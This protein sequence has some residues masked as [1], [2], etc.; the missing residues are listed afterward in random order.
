[1]NVKYIWILWQGRIR[2][3]IGPV[4]GGGGLSKGGGLGV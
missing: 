3:Q 2:R 4:G 1:M